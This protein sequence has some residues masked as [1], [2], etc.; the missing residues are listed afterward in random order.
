[1]LI[2]CYYCKT[3]FKRKKRYRR[4]D[5][6]NSGNYKTFCGNACYNA[7]RCKLVPKECVRCGAVFKPLK[8]KQK[9]CNADCYFGRAN[10]A[11]PLEIY[12]EGAEFIRIYRQHKYDRGVA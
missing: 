9:Y 11:A 3:V 1:M 6:P 2:T 12:G 8:Q 5:R 4:S 10:P 7:L